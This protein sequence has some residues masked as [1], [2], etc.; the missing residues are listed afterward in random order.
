MS[1]PTDSLGE[2]G[3]RRI[4]EALEQVHDPEIPALSIVDLG[5]LRGIETA[6]DGTTV[7]R[8]TPTYTG[9]PATRLIELEVRAALDRAGFPDVRVETVLSPPWT[10]DWITERGRQRLRE[11]GIAP[12]E[13]GGDRA[14]LFGPEPEVACPRCG[15]ADT[16]R[17]SEFGSTACKALYRCRSCREP[18]EYFKCL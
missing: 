2:A 9:C 8:I 4:L 11:A 17:V 16:E 14:S 12:P 5:I 13:R 7:V 15:S 6:P 3:R 1:A 18:F 10:T